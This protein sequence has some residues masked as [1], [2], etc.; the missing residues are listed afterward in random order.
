MKH[1]RAPLQ[2]WRIVTTLFVLVIHYCLLF[3]LEPNIS[4]PLT[5]SYPP[6]QEN[7]LKSLMMTMPSLLSTVQRRNNKILKV[8][9]LQ[10]PFTYPLCQFVK[11]LNSLQRLPLLSSGLNPSSSY[12]SFSQLHPSYSRSHLGWIPT[13]RSPLFPPY[14]YSPL[15]Y[16]QCAAWCQCAVVPQN[17]LVGHL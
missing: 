2:E 16:Y 17:G 1:P 10:D 15:P 8:S 12:C 13:Y 9:V 6:R 7:P 11:I 5:T 3:L 4:C 14:I